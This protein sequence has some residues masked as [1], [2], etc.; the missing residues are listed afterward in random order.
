MRNVRRFR[1]F[2]PNEPMA[3]S[4]GTPGRGRPA[5]R[6]SRWLILAPLFLSIQIA[7]L[8]SCTQIT[9]KNAPM[10]GT[11]SINLPQSVGG[12]TRTGVPRRVGPQEIFDYMDG[13]GELYLGY[14]FKFLEAYHYTS[15]SEDEILVELYW[16]ESSDDAYG[17]LSGDWGG[18]AVDPKGGTPAASPGAATHGAAGAAAGVGA[19]RA[20]YGAGLLRLWSDNLF[21]RIMATHETE[22]SRKAV[23]ALGQTIVAGRTSPSEPALVKAL[24]LRIGSRYSLRSD[25]LTFLRSHLVLNSVYFL[26]SENVLDLGPGCELVAASYRQGRANA[27]G[28]PVRLL[29][30][31]YPNDESAQKA[32]SHFRRIYLPEKHRGQIAGVSED[33]GAASIEDGWMGFARSGRTLALVY[34][35]PDER[36]V[37]LFLEDAT[38]NLEQ[39]EATRE[40]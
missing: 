27:G 19:P 12:W 16:M 28:K 24:P 6:R 17:L 11:S 31:R 10:A 21:A 14:R 36:S 39:L 8:S 3:G 22:A 40:R 5:A 1:I 25:R 37:R 30:A 34:E 7:L 20:L 18:E 13:A 29:L 4:S 15:P 9:K 32:L 26:S 23:Y 38:Q 35:S 33:K 2:N